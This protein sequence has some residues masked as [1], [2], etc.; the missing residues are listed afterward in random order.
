MSSIVFDA[1]LDSKKLEDG[2]KQSNK[3]V[4]EWARDV[5]KN[6][7]KVDQSINKIGRSFVN[8]GSASIKTTH[9]TNTAL[10]QELGLIEDIENAIAELKEQRKGAH[11]IEDIERYNKKIKEAELNLKEYTEAG[12][13]SAETTETLTKTVGKWALSLGGA[14]AILGL[15]KKAF[16]ETTGGIN[17]F[18]QVGAVTDQILYDITSGA[19]VT[20]TKLQSAI[21]LQSRLNDLRLKEYGDKVKIAASDTE[22]QQLYSDS[23]DAS[24]SKAERISV[25]DAALAAHNKS[26]DLRLEN[27]REN[28]DYTRD[29]LVDKPTSDKLLKQLTDLMAEEYKLEGERVASTKRLVRQ[30]STLIQEGIEE[31][32]KYREDYANWLK[33]IED[34]NV[35]YAKEQKEEAKKIRDEISVLKLEGKDKD[36]EVLKQKY[37]KD[38]ETYKFNEDAKLSLKEKYELEKHAIEIKY[39][40]ELQ[41][42]NQKYLEGIQKIDPGKGYSILNRSLEASGDKPL[43]FNP[44]SVDLKKP[45]DSSRWAKAMQKAN[46]DTDEAQQKALTEELRLRQ[47]ITGEVTDLVFQLAEA[48]GMSESGLESLGSAL[49]AFQSAVSGDW[50]GTV[51]SLLSGLIAM[52]PDEAAKFQKQIDSINSALEKQQR[53]IELAGRTGG[54]AE[55][56]SKEIQQLY[57]LKDATFAALAAERGKYNADTDR[58]N[59][60]TAS[61]EEVKVQIEEAEQAQVDFIAG[62][63]TESTIADAIVQGFREGKTSVDDFG[64][65]MN[66]ALLDAVLNVFKAEILGPRITEITKYIQAALA[67]KVLTGDEKTEIDRMTKEAADA[68]KQIWEQLTGSLD[69]G[70]GPQQ[71]LS[72]QISRS[73]TEE[74][75][76]ELAGLFRRF[77]DDERAIKDYSKLGLNHL[78]GIENNT[79][80]TVVQLQLAVVELKNIVNNTKQIPTGAL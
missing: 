78:V 55:A 34:D 69:L 14:T 62:G 26:I 10:K 71:G 52:I 25:I 35:L 5:E 43:S 22:Y 70:N 13:K 6:A 40:K 4:K 38:I 73:I 72:G 49:D 24:L 66:D 57:D 29:A 31:E 65:Y 7:D 46:Q 59:E 32:K 23:L 64:D 44:K 56:R 80:Q 1:S 3:T 21:A 41:K 53:L 51:T 54:E 61:W 27:V 67:D 33:E 50:I 9:A 42:E 76:S 75:G 79:F 15:L 39:L 28:L 17:L 60:L 16:M 19:T 77:A 74:T 63:V 20:I 37:D 36:L 48:T 8:S 11:S 30:R 58:I 47:Q 12:I 2:I 45:A 18:N 68:N